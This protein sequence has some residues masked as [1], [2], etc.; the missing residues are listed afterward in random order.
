M[1]NE[2]AAGD[3]KE[4]LLTTTLNNSLFQHTTSNKETLREGGDAA[5]GDQPLHVV[6]GDRDARAV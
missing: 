2:R 1:P 5:L 3:D 6:E 4:T